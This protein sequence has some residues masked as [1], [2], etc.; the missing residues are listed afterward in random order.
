MQNW[1]SE[2]PRC[3]TDGIPLKELDNHNPLL[4]RPG[5]FLFLLAE[6]GTDRPVHACDVV[7]PRRLA[8]STRSS[9]TSS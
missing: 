5:M 2:R 6:P 1:L 9:A 4:Q 8:P 3:E 7:A